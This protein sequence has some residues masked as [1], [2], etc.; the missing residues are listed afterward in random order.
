[1]TF[2]SI[3]WIYG[4]FK[5]LNIKRKRRKRGK[6]EKNL[7]IIKLFP[8]LFPLFLDCLAIKLWHNS[9]QSIF[10]FIVLTH[11]LQSYYNICISIPTIWINNTFSI[12]YIVYRLFIDSIH[13]FV[14]LFFFFFYMDEKK[15]WLVLIVSIHNHNW[16]NFRTFSFNQSFYLFT[17]NINFSMISISYE[18]IYISIYAWR[19]TWAHTEHSCTCAGI[20]EN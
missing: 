12:E 3:D 9:E 17:L 19:C 4:R 6:N 8:Y 2:N 5:E 10:I 7:W 18:D 11:S 13:L 16:I 1:M 20:G 15:N 14:F